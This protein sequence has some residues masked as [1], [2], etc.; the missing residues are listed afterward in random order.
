MLRLGRTVLQ[1][2]TLRRMLA[3]GI[4]RLGGVLPDRS[5][6]G[7][8][9]P[10][11]VGCPRLVGIGLVSRVMPSILLEAVLPSKSVGTLFAVLGIH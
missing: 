10:P 9:M 11:R 1:R 3:G 5:R 4:R 6:R 8:T 7:A 2:L